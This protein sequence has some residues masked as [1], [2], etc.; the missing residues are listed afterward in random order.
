M[1]EL[2][3]DP[4]FTAR[5][6]A[7]QSSDAAPLP[8]IAIV[9]AGRLGTAI[10]RAAVAAGLE[11][12]LATRDDA[13]AKAAQ[14]EI[15]LLC[16]PDAAIAEA[17]AAI[18]GPAPGP[19]FVGHTSGATGIEA[20]DSARARGAEVFSLHPLQ[21]IPDGDAELAGAPCAI[22]A[23]DSA[24]AGVAGRLAAAL[25]MR[26]FDLP[27]SSRGAYHAAAAIASNFLVTL[28][29]SAAEVLRRAGIDQPRAL[30]GPLVLRTAVNWSERGGEALTGPIARGDEATIERHLDALEKLYP[31]LLDAYR[32][33]AERTRALTREQTA[34]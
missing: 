7:T 2:E 6:S 31:E 1:R 11:V 10:H 9:G 28:E 13:G 5:S 18:P 21:T 3:R 33:L 22:T 17:C 14:A 32:A 8:A 12:E 16:V 27:E 20:L 19:R 30:L 15:A 4:N 25:G 24:A 34:A 23:S 26:P 29:E